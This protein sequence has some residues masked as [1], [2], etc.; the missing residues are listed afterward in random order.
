MSLMGKV[1]VVTGGGSGIGRAIAEQLAKDGAAISVWDLNG[2]GAQETVDRILR[3]DGNAIACVGDASSEN[4]IAKFC[5]Q[6][7]QTLG[8]ITI[9]I[10]NAA[11]TGLTNFLNINVAEWDRMMEINL[12]GPFLCSQAIIPD[13]P[14]AGWGRTVNISSSSAQAGS[15]DM[16]HYAASK[17]GIVGFTKGLAMEFAPHGITVNNIPP[18]FVD[19]PMLRSMPFDVAATAS[20]S[21]MKRPGKPEDIA[22]ACSYLVSEAAG[23][24]TGHTLS[25]NGGRY[26]S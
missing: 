15:V 19:T 18:G 13:M 14:A 17:G 4:D 7:R 24:V 26:L 3:K 11:I 10:N 20:Q 22:A 21:P 1:A 23:Y 2:I 8:P 25:V 16:V 5:A 6:T 12:R 9:L